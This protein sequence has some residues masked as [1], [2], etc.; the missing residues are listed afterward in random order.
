MVVVVVMMVW[1]EAMRMM[2]VGGG[3]GFLLNGPLTSVLQVA[4]I[5]AAAP[6]GAAAVGRPFRRLLALLDAII[7]T[8]VGG[9]QMSGVWTTTVGESV[10]G[11]LL[12]SGLTAGRTAPH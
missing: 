7:A 1:V 10:H 4:V 6:A 12:V 11:R 8:A 2:E 5:A 9:G 3:G